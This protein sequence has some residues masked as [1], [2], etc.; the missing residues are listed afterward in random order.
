MNRLT[1]KFLCSFFQLFGGYIEK[2]EILNYRVV[3][4]IKY[5]DDDDSQCFLWEDPF[6]ICLEDTISLIDTIHDYHWN[7]GD[8]I[9]VKRQRLIEQLCE[10]GW[11]INRANEA[12]ECL[13]NIK[14]FM[15]DN[16]EITDS[17]FVHF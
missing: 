17:F 4:L 9:I 12:I 3:G 15:I 7:N 1:V 11:Q 5:D 16:N 14:V 2:V 13:L 10:K 8:K 6:H